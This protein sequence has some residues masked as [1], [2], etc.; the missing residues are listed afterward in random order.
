MPYSRPTASGP[1]A[2]IELILPCLDEAEG[3]RWLLP[4]VPSGDRCRRG[5]QRIGRRVGRS[6]AQQWG[7]GVVQVTQ[8][9]LRRRL[10]RRSACRS[11]R[12]RGG[13]GRRR[14]LRS[15]RARAGSS[16]RCANGTYDLMIG[17]RRPVSRGAQPWQLRL[18]NRVL[19]RRLNR[20]TGLRLHDLGPTR[21]GAPDGPARARPDRPPVGLPGRDRGP[22][23]RRGLAD[24]RD[25][26]GLPGPARS[27]EG[28]RDAAGCLASRPD[29]STALIRG[30]P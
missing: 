9:G 20:R 26:V 29:M 14:Q 6:L 17:A 21:A 30:R 22:R 23:R 27:L 8:T 25:L 2:A 15:G 4:R 1:I 3:L 5:R 18:A 28:D 13:D 10:P 12:D 19:A 7:A 24:R 16:R 11:R